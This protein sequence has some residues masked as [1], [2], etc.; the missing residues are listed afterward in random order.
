MADSGR[1]FKL[2]CS[3]VG[4]PDL[5]SLDIADFGRWAKLGAYIKE[6]GSDGEI[7]LT[8]PA[9]V[10]VSMLQLSSFQGV[11][12]AARRFKNVTV[13]IET[14]EPVSIF[15]KYEN[16][17]KYQGDFSTDRVRKHRAKKAENETAKK[18]GEEKRGEEIIA[19]VE[20]LFM[21]YPFRN[22]KKIGRQETIQAI[23]DHVKS[24]EYDLLLKAATNFAAN[25]DAK[26]G[27][28][29]KDLQRFIISGRGEKKCFPWKE[30][31]NQATK[32]GDPGLSGPAGRDPGL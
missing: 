8:E 1:W 24:E 31:I 30:W 22:G 21:T 15:I 19:L 14:N 7:T 9:R 11:I 16:W 17:F 28:G 12:D 20:K 6:H 32:Q 27:I 5:D 13:S 23:T 10:I 25:P 4:D 29:V 26:K 3:S 2:W 18:R